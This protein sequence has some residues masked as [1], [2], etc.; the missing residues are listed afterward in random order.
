MDGTFFSSNKV[1]FLLFRKNSSILFLG[2]HLQGAGDIL[3][4]DEVHHLTAVVGIQ[5]L[6]VQEADTDLDLDLRDPT[7]PHHVG[8]CADHG[9]RHPLPDVE[10]SKCTQFSPF[11]LV[12]IGYVIR[13]S[14]YRMRDIM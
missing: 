1:T 12:L 6:Q 2:G 8:P 10:V 13:K 9:A 3:L 14:S 5:D 11:E 4:T 7:D